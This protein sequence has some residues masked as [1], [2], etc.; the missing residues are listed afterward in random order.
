MPSLSAA[1]VSPRS[2]GGYQTGINPPKALI[3]D[4]D[5]ASRELL[6]RALAR[7]GLDTVETSD[8]AEGLRALYATRPDVVILDLTMP[9]VDGWTVLERIRELSDLPVL[10]VSALAHEAEKVRALQAGADDYMTKPVGVQE[11][12]ARVAALLRRGRAPVELEAIYNDALVQVD[13][14][15]AEGRVAGWVVPLTRREFA[16]LGAFVRHPGQTLSAEQLAGL[17]WGDPIAAENR[18]KILVSRLRQKVRAV[19][20]AEI[21]IE[22]VRGFGYRYAPPSD[23]SRGPRR[24]V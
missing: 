18:V 11:M 2:R 14:A 20:G 8:G 16:L 10:V 22:T 24:G 4:D 13:H 17:T 12:R 21:P 3:V 6:R 23:G 5:P 19:S 7:A 1:S 9:E 15:R